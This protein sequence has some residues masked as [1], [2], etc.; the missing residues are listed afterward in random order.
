M[1]R[2]LLHERNNYRFAVRCVNKRL[3]R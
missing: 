3:N 1:L 2:C